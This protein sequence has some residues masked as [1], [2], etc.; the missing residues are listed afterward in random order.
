M[1]DLTSKHARPL[2]M[3]G[4]FAKV[5]MRELTPKHV[6]DHRPRDHR[7]QTTPCAI[8]SVVLSYLIPW[9]FQERSFER[10]V[11]S[12]RGAYWSLSRRRGLGLASRLFCKS[13]DCLFRDA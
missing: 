13:S 4:W 8:H 2:S 12:Q 9:F 10:E 3:R 5:I 1:Q 6:G 11:R 7:Q